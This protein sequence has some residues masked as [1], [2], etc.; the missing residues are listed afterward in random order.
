MAQLPHRFGLIFH[1]LY[2]LAS[3]FSTS[4]TDELIAGKITGVKLWILLCM[5][6]MAFPAGADY[7]SVRGR[8]PAVV[9]DGIIEGEWLPFGKD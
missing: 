1:W 7:H 8:L 4:F 9:S 2:T 6:A 3:S 5:I